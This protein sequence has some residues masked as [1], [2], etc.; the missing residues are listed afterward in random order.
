[1]NQGLSQVE[2]SFSRLQFRSLAEIKSFCR[3][4]FCTINNLN[5]FKFP[6]LFLNGISDISLCPQATVQTSSGVMYKLSEVPCMMA[7]AGFEM[8]DDD[9]SRWETMVAAELVS[10]SQHM[11]RCKRPASA[12][13]EAHV[14]DVPR[15]LPMQPE[16]TQD[17][18]INI[19]WASVSAAN[20]ARQSTSGHAWL[21][22]HK[23]VRYAI[24]Q[25]FFPPRVC[26]SYAHWNLQ[27]GKL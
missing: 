26:S 2:R 3:G 8:S 20:T 18:D 21:H 11:Q 17:V 16:A 7:C 23:A 19:R 22:H 6:S 1:M 4:V 9:S 10:K 15:E 27:P 13:E 24:L 25:S 5:S 12:I 14:A